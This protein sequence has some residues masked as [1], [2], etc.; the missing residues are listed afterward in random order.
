MYVIVSGGGEAWLR[1]LV[2]AEESKEASYASTTES[3]RQPRGDSEVAPV[4]QHLEHI[5]AV[6]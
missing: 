1:R 4:R 2:Y 5:S 3:V 6:S